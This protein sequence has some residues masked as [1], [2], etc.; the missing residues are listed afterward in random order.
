MRRPSLLARSNEGQRPRCCLQNGKPTTSV[1]WPSTH[2]QSTV[3]CFLSLYCFMQEKIYISNS[4]DCLNVASVQ[5]RLAEILWYWTATRPIWRQ[6]C[7]SFV[8]ILVLTKNCAD[9]NCILNKLRYLKWDFCWLDWDAAE[10]A[11]SQQ[12]HVPCIQ[13]CLIANWLLKYQRQSL[14]DIIKQGLAHFVEGNR[15]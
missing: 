3:L 9:M 4:Y 11:C 15:L 1:L 6:V 14:Q 13:E 8:L 7:S 12:L 2:V 10:L 5:I